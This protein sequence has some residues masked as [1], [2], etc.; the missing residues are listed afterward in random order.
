MAAHLAALNVY[1][2]KSCAGIAV[3]AASLTE[4]GLAHDRQ[5]MVVEAGGD[6][7]QP[8]RF[9]TQRE[10]PRLALIRTRLTDRSLVLSAPGAGE[11]DIAFDRDGPRG[12]ATVWRD[13]VPAID[14]GD[15]IARWLSHFVGAPLRL[16][17]F[18]DA[19]RRYCNRAFAGD[20][21]AHTAFA[22]GYPL[23]VIG[24][25]SLADLNARLSARGA[26]VLP[27]NRF[28][29]NL[30]IDGLEPYDEDHLSTIA[31]GGDVA[32]RLVK[33][34]VRCRITTT[35]Q[36]TAIVGEEP[37]ATLAGY[38]MNARLDGLTFGINAIVERG[39]G[40]AI[41]CGAPIAVEWAF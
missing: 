32:L 2:V 7:S 9:V 24:S 25:A 16:V 1:P 12:L 28:R 33:P 3:D 23:L 26:D 30:V 35:D 13:T 39:A 21:G 4:R 11:H 27:M 6:A 40:S 14:Q 15:S 22:D 10:H 5:W 36:D 8:A 17:R 20:S 31:I 38:R 37:L 18:D 34:C 41:E 19:H 29:P